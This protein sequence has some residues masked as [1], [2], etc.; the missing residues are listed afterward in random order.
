MSFQMC[1]IGLFFS[2]NFFFGNRSRIWVAEPGKKWEFLD[3]CSSSKMQQSPSMS[4]NIKARLWQWTP[5]AGYIKGHF[6]V[7]RSSL[8]ENR[9][10]SNYFYFLVENVCLKC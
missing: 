5:T 4:K 6:H 3:F 9:L 7:L 8:K 10:I 2:F 1:L